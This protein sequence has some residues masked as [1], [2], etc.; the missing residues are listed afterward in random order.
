VPANYFLLLFV[1]DDLTIVDAV[2]VEIGLDCIV[3]L[4]VSV[5]AKAYLVFVA[6][7]FGSFRDLL[8]KLVTYLLYPF[9]DGKCNKYVGT[10]FYVEIAVCITLFIICKVAGFNFRLF[11]LT[12]LQSSSI[13]CM[14]S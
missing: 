13:S 6:W 9:S 10:S 3:V 11:F 8:V 7:L 1:F 12:K 14:P 2:F 5:G 4:F